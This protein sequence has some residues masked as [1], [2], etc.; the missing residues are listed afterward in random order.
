MIHDFIDTYVVFGFILLTVF[1]VVAARID[2]YMSYRWSR[3][4]N[5]EYLARVADLV[6]LLPLVKTPLLLPPATV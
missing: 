3:V 1:I 6:E 2:R 4:L 5:A